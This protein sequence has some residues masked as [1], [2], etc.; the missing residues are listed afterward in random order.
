MLAA[1]VLC[2]LLLGTYLTGG[3]GEQVAWGASA[4]STQIFEDGAHGDKS[5]VASAWGSNTTAND[6]DSTAFGAN[7]KASGEYS[8]AF[9]N[10]TVASGSIATAWGNSAKAYGPYSTAFGKGTAGDKDDNNRHCYCL[11]LSCQSIWRF[12]HS[13]RLL[14]EGQRYE[15]YSIRLLHEGQR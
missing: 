13:V 5:K 3:Y 15:F 2:T 8:T 4:E 6:T 10:G 1:R 11:G 9:G 12:F 14:H 7:T